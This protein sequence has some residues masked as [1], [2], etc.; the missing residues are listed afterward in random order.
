MLLIP[1]HH[2]IL[3]WHKAEDDGVLLL[4]FLKYGDW[5]AKKNEKSQKS[6]KFFG[7]NVW[8]NMGIYITLQV[9]Q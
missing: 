4:E 6:C 5:S 2:Q 3:R 8:E 7:R 9:K 1:P